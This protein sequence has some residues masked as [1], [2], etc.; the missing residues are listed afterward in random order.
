M[1]EQIAKNIIEKLK[2]TNNEFTYIKDLS[3]NEVC[4]IL[5]VSFRNNTISNSYR[6]TYPGFLLVSLIENPMIVE[7]KFKITNKE[8]LYLS[9]SLHA[10]YYFDSTKFV[11]FK[12]KSFF[13]KLKL[14]DGEIN[15]LM[16]SSRFNIIN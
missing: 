14:V 13:M 5:F 16:N 4:K 1:H 10:P 7:G 11:I 6:L 15:T 9:N 2:D 3:I 8:L 12:D